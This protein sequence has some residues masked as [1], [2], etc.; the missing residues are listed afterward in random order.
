[1]KKTFYLFLI[2]MF[3]F[4]ITGCTKQNKVQQQTTPINQNQDTTFPESGNRSDTGNNEIGEKLNEKDID[5][6][7]KTSDFDDID[8]LLSNIDSMDNE[9]DSDIKEIDSIEEDFVDE[10]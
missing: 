6:I 9:T 5:E 1:M 3:C 4:T 7:N 2:V 10:E 8:K